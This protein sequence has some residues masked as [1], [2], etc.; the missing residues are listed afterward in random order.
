MPMS[1]RRI[2][3]DQEEPYTGS[4]LAYAG[5]RELLNLPPVDLGRHPNL[6]APL[7]LTP[8]LDRRLRAAAGD[9]DGR[10]Y[11]IDLLRACMF[12]VLRVHGGRPRLPAARGGM[13]EILG[14]AILEATGIEIS[15]QAT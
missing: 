5:V 12:A 3:D 2:P 10:T 7:E 11:N 4:F 8:E 6:D 13:L 1:E 15:E 9:V 14:I